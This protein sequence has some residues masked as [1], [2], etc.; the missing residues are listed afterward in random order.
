MMAEIHDSIVNRF[1]ARYETQ[2]GERGLKLSG[3]TN[4]KIFLYYMIINISRYIE[5]N[6][7]KSAKQGNHFVM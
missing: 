1:P 2:V 6:T 4:K 3:K 7:G 5:S